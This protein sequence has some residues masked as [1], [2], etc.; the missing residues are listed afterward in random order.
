MKGQLRRQVNPN[1][2]VY[3]YPGAHE[4]KHKQEFKPVPSEYERVRSRKVSK[5][6]LANLE[7]TTQNLIVSVGQEQSRSRQNYS[8]HRIKTTF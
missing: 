3:N 1:V 4:L 5:Q 7:S 6:K 2:P 8:L